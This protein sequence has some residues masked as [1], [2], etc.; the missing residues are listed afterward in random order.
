MGL[1]RSEKRL[2]TAL[3]KLVE[4]SHATDEFERI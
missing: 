2:A 3:E 1:E 4:A